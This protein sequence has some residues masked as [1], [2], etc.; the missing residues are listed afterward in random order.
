MSAHYPTPADL[1]AFRRSIP[2][3]HDHTTG[4]EGCPFSTRDRA[5]DSELQHGIGQRGTID[6]PPFLPIHR[7]EAAAMRS[8]AYTRTVGRPYIP[9]PTAAADVLERMYG[10]P[11]AWRGAFPWRMADWPELPDRECT[12]DR[13]CESGCIGEP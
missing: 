6:A 4:W 11:Y 7:R 5:Y 3:T 2:C 10:I 13:P 12:H 9:D 1:A 8:R